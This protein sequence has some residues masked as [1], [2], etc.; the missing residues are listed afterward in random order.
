MRIPDGTLV[1]SLARAQNGERSGAEALLISLYPAISRFLSRR[2]GRDTRTAGIV[3][4]LVQESMLRVAQQMDRCNAHADGQVVVWALT[5][6]RRVA[7]E[8]FRNWRSGIALAAAS[9]QLRPEFLPTPQEEAN[10]HADLTGETEKP[11]VAVLLSRFAVEA[12]NELP[13]ATMDVIWARL[14]EEASWREI[15]SRLGLTETAVKKRYQRAQDDVRRTVLD[16]VAH[17]PDP[18]RVRVEA[19][20]NRIGA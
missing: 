18:D 2:F 10:E 17:L 16:R 4:D 12:Q 6:A 7:L 15:G 14:M 1:Q 20:L 5:V 11:S 9:I 13:E 8:H 19:Y 3:E